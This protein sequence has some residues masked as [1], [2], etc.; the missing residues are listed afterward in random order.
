[1]RA[2]NYPT[3]R[4]NFCVEQLRIRDNFVS[5]CCCSCI[6][7]FRCSFVDLLTLSAR[8]AVGKMQKQRDNSISHRY[9]AFGLILFRTDDCCRVCLTD[10]TFIICAV[11]TRCSRTSIIFR[12]PVRLHYADAKR[13]I[14]FER[15]QLFYFL[16]TF[17][18][19]WRKK[20][21]FQLCAMNMSSVLLSREFRHPIE[22][23]G[24][25]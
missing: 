11:C 17:C 6:R 5:S 25:V 4:Y 3:N 10:E 1:M 24:H 8:D 22:M 21:T 18:Y 12:F 16:H 20:N 9:D 19:C 7:Y 2:I 13:H 14:S 15:H 23:M